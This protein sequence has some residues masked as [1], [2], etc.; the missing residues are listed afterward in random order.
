MYT[1][2]VVVGK[3]YEW[4]PPRWMNEDITAETVFTREPENTKASGL[5]HGYMTKF[6]ETS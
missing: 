1:V 4:I 2:D 6:G 5:L 3:S